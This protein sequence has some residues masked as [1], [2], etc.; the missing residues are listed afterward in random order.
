M[1]RFIAARTAEGMRKVDIKA[2]WGKY[3]R[4]ISSAIPRSYALLLE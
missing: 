4:N 2:Q 3:L 1:P